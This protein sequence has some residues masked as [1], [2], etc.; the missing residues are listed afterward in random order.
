[1][2]EEELLKLADDSAEHEDGET[3]LLRCCEIEAERRGL[4]PE[5]ALQAANL[6]FRRDAISAGIPASVVDG[7]TKLRDHFSES[8]IDFMCGRDRK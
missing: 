6:A 3:G 7:K 4:T 5:I 1:M 2:T 8:Y